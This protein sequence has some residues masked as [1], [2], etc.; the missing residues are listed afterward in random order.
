[1]N[2]TVQKYRN[3]LERKKGQRAQLK[4]QIRVTNKKLTDLKQS[5]ED[6]LAAQAIIFDQ[7]KKTQ[8]QLEYH[9]SDIVSKAMSSVFENPYELKLKFTGKG[10]KIAV[11]MYFTK[12]ENIYG[13]KQG[14]GGGTRN[15]ASLALRLSVWTLKMPRT[16]PV[17][18]LDEPLHFLKGENLPERGATMI[19]EISKTIGLQI[20]MVSHD[21]DLIAGA[22]KIFNIVKKKKVSRVQ[23]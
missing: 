2:N 19:K 11:E 7:A 15:I 18:F 20:I 10:G 1:M 23:K 16:R 3:I 4:K 12:N 13:L 9:L 6:N 8:E 5:L 21:P 14:I 17:I 22:D